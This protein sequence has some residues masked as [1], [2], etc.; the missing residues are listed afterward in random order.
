M[1]EIPQG[2]D[3]SALPG[4]RLSVQFANGTAKTHDVAPLTRLLPAF[5]ALEDE[6]LFGN[7][8]VYGI[9]W[10]DELDFACDE[11]WDIGV[12]VATPFDDLVSFSDVSKL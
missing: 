6:V 12:E 9:V 11:L 1:H 2:R 3:V 10:N 4:M 5:A 8:E 7:A